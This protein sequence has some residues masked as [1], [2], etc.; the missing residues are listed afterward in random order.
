M[1][2]QKIK[3]FPQKE[4]DKSGWMIAR[5]FEKGNAWGGKRSGAFSM[6]EKGSAFSLTEKRRAFSMSE[7]HYERNARGIYPFFARLNAQILQILSTI[8]PIFSAHSSVCQTKHMFMPIV[9]HLV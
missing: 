1:P 6:T 3:L 2:L 7:K 8:L 5:W 9:A 4:F